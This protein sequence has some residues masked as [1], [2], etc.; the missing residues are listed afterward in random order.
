MKSLGEFQLECPIIH[1]DTQG[2]KYTYAD[3]PKIYSVIN[4]LLAKHGLVLT[5]PLI[6]K[7]IKTILFHLESG[8]FIEADTPIPQVQLGNMNDYQAY[9]SGVTYFRRYAISSILGL[10]T[11]K[12]LDAAGT[13]V[14]ATKK[15]E[16]KKVETSNKA[17]MNDVLMIKLVARY[18]GG[19][20]DVFTRAEEHFTLRK[21]DFDIINSLKK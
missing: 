15:L 17:E 16:E 6:E 19:E 7:G 1:K 14:T 12:D 21:K 18:N 4:P 2:H 11:D 9:G 13:Q 5:Q 8:E 10:V 3:L 20:K